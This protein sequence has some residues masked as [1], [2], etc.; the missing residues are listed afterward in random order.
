MGVLLETNDP[1]F[2]RWRKK[3]SS[4]E[5]TTS[6]ENVRLNTFEFSKCKTNENSSLQQ[7]LLSHQEYSKMAESS[8]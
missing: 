4:P 6:V 2:L 7:K 8:S 3:K 5:Q 1:Y